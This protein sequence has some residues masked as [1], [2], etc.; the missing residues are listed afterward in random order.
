LKT[1]E[2]VFNILCV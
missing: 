2:I 1:W